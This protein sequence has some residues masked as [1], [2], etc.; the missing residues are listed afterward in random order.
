MPKFTREWTYRT[1]T[2]TVTYPDAWD[3]PLSPDIETAAR[4]A[5]ALEEPEPE[6]TNGDDGNGEPARRKG[7]SSAAQGE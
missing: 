4:T 6:K 2:T 3:G 7:R 1:P 5:K